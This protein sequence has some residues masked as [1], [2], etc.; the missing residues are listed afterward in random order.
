MGFKRKT[1]ENPKSKI[2]QLTEKVKEIDNLAPEPEQPSQAVYTPPT[3][4]ERMEKMRIK[5]EE[6]EDEAILVKGVTLHQVQFTKNVPVCTYQE[7]RL[8]V[9]RYKDLVG[10]YLL[11]GGDV[12]V[13]RD[14]HAHEVVCKQQVSSYI[15]KRAWDAHQK[16]KEYGKR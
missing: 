6:Q 5:I 9:G 13:V 7:T 15:T 1:K 8:W 16:M 3:R 14:G 10:L 4:E 2:A 11:P 12:L